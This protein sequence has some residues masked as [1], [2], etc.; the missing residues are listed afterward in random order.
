MNQLNNDRYWK[1]FKLPDLEINS[2]GTPTLHLRQVEAASEIDPDCETI[3]YITR[4][5]FNNGV[6]L[7]VIKKPNFNI[8]PK[9]TISFGGETGEFFYQREPY[10]TGRDVYYIDTSKLT[11]DCKK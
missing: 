11:A 4:G 10:V 5:K 9:N 2:Y 7:R 1:E 8:I 6:K 3:N